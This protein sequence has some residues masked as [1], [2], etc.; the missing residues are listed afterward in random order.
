HEKP[1]GGETS[2]ETM[3]AILRHDPPK[4]P[5]VDGLSAAV[6]RIVRRCLEKDPELRFQSARDVAFALEATTAAETAVGAPR[7]RRR[8]W[9]RWIAT[10]ATGLCLAFGAYLLGAGKPAPRPKLPSFRRLTFRRGFVAS[11]RLTADG[12]TVVYSASWEGGGPIRMYTRP[13]AGRDAT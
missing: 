10:L 8:R 4:L 6:D 3:T 5:S 2:A 12:A 7:P 11:A 1:F 13:V 9:L